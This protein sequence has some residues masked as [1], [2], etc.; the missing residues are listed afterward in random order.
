MKGIMKCID[1]SNDIWAHMICVNYSLGID[2]ID[3]AKTKVK[4][5]MTNERSSLQ[6]N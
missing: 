5:Y 4:G 1:K 2:F 3:E 6:C